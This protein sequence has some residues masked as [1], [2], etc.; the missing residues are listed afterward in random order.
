MLQHAA[1]D[2]HRNSR[3][4]ELRSQGRDHTMLFSMPETEDLKCAFLVL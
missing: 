2:A 1:K 4:L 3:L